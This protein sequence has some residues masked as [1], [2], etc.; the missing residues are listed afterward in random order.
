MVH[1]TY[2]ILCMSYSYTYITFMLIYYTI[3]YVLFSCTVIM[4]SFHILFILLSLSCTVLVHI[5]FVSLTLCFLYLYTCHTI[6]AWQCYASHIISSLFTCHNQ[7]IYFM[8]HACKYQRSGYM[9]LIKARRR[10]THY[11]KQW[12]YQGP[13][14]LYSLY[15]IVVV[16]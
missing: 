11:T 1:I 6:I 9:R 13:K 2:P 14:A 10:Y 3:C 7:I 12:Y 8:F 16:S 4:Y 5:I 15:E